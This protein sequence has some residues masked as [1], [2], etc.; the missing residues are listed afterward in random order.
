VSPELPIQSPSAPAPTPAARSV[1]TGNFLWTLAGNLIYA[2]CQWGILV[3][4]A[5][6][7]NSEMLGQ[8]ALGL[9]ITA[10]VFQFCGLQLRAVQVTDARNKYPFGELAGMRLVTTAAGLV[11]VMALAFWGRNPRQTALVVVLVGLSKA[12]ESFSDLCQGLFQKNERMDRVAKSLILKGALSVPIV[13]IALRLSGGAAVACAMLVIAWV[14]AWIG[15]DL[16]TAV[17]QLGGYPK[18]LFPHIDR[19]VFRNLLV[20]TLPL[21]FVMMLLSLNANLPRYFL[22]KYAGETSVGVFSALMYC[23]VAGNMVMSALGQTASPRL[24]KLHFEG[25]LRAFCVLLAK[26]VAFGTVTGIIGLIAVRLA[27]TRILT[28]L[29]RPEYALHVRAFFWLMAAGTIMNVSGVLGVAV[30]AMQGFRQQAWI[31]LGC[32]IIGLAASFLLVP[33]MGIL[34]AAFSVLT[35]AVAVLAGYSIQLGFMVAEKRAPSPLL[36]ISR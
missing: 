15:Y 19:S 34:G 5:K 13:A 2:L 8:Y 3:S 21:G 9:A 18:T 29:Y 14:F 33:S 20:L 11:I 1:L 35:L 4:F 24:A 16:R 12:I 30:T 7:G 22:A 26:L 25:D 36:A 6:L 28:L 23:I 17:K 27:G 10:P 32:F 31:H